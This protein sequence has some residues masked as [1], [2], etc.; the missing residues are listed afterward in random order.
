GAA[1]AHVHGST[2]YTTSVHV[3]ALQPKRW[4]EIVN[5]HASQV[6]SLVDLLQGR[7]PK[8]L[9]EALADRSSG[10]FP[11]PKELKFECSCPDYASMCK[12]VAAVLYGVGARLDTQ[13]ELF[14]L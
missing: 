7:L 4:K 9:L 12:H 8:S 13:P 14:F 5:R 6:G 2:L 1:H 10:L 11:P 3:Q